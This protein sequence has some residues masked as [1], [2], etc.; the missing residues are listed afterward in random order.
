[1]SSKPIQGDYGIET[2][3]PAI[4][5][6]RTGNPAELFA[7]IKEWVEVRNGTRGDGLDRAVT[8]RDLL[9]AGL[10]SPI[11][12]NRLN[13][14]GIPPIP[15]GT[16]DTDP[17]IP[18]TPEHLE[19]VGS[20][21]Y[22]ILTWEFARGYSRLA[23]FEVWR[24]LTDNIA[25]AIQ[26]GQ[27]FAPIYADN[28]GP[29]KSYYY[30]VRAVSDAAASPFNALSGTLGQTMMDVGYLIGLLTGR[31][32]A[33]ELSNTLGARI[34]LIDGAANLPG[35]VAARIAQEVGDRT[36]YVQNYTYSKS[37]VDQS[38]SFLYNATRA[39]Y[40]AYADAA[41]ASA[42]STASADVRSYA[43]SVA[44][45]DAAIATTASTLRSEFASSAGVSAAY[46]QNYTFSKA[47][48]NSAIAT[49]TAQVTARLDNI[50]GITLEQKF[51]AQAGVNTGLSAQYTFKIDNNNYIS[52]FGLAST[53][54]N[55]TPYSSAIFRSDDFA[56]GSPSGPGIAPSFPFI[57]QT[58][59]TTLN[60]VAV[61]AGVYMT[62]AFIINGAITNAKIGNL[63]VD[64]AKIA[65][66][67]VA[68]LLAGSIDVGT[69]I[70]STNYLAGDT[71]WRIHGNGNSEFGNTTVRGGIYASYGQIGGSTIDSTG[72]QSTNYGS[73]TGWRV[74]NGGAAVFNE[75]II[76]GQLIAAFGTL[77]T[78][79]LCDIR[80]GTSGA[81]TV[82][83]EKGATVYD[84]ANTKR[85]QWGDL[86]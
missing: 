9:N 7:A 33:S 43:Y 62:A 3:T 15:L 22:I 63:A 48:A 11:D 67:S 4:P 57:V 69:Y 13:P 37:D 73:T 42:I 23:Y 32:S 49:S 80:S 83:S 27:T 38:Q 77:G 25:D 31:I 61:P 55:G 52:G 20:F 70:Q 5:D 53:P 86:S 17:D 26:I 60:G 34:N 74:S 85:V 46:V 76:R 12:L 41:K 65:N 35:S 84:A 81:R 56:I 71:G 66:L 64:D 40:R 18:P 75:A 79:T 72:I 58:T 30:W 39:E 45:T 16:G 47:E 29:G 28:V 51:T 6:V 44:G 82:T 8:L 68:K 78:I 59:P 54:V 36:T 10:A 2:R 19:A 21:K 14:H 1:M 24:S 50:G